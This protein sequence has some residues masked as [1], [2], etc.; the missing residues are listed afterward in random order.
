MKHLLTLDLELLDEIVISRNSATTGQHRCLPYIPGSGLLGAAASRL[1]DETDNRMYDIFHS[2]QVRFGDGR[3]VA[4]GQLASWPVPFAWHG[5]K[6]GEATHDHD[7]WLAAGIFSFVAAGV[8]ASG[9]IQPQQIR[10]GFVSETG[11][12][13]RP[14]TRYRMKTAIDRRTG[15]A[16]ESQLF[17]YEALARGQRFRATIRSNDAAHLE[18]LRACLNDVI[19]LGR[20]RSA[21]YGRVRVSTSAVATAAPAFLP[22]ALLDGAPHLV[23]WLAS[24]LAVRNTETGMPTLTP[25]LHDLGLADLVGGSPAPGRTFVRTRRYIPYN[26]RRGSHDLERQVIVAG[27]VLCYRLHEPPAPEIAARLAARLA[28]GL[29]EN[30]EAGLGDVVLDP[31]LEQLLL[32]PHPVFTPLAAP[33]RVQSV[34]EPSH[35]LIA[36]L[37]AGEERDDAETSANRWAERKLAALV[38]VCDSARQYNGIAADLACGPTAAQWGRV[39]EAAIAHGER[40]A[41][42]NALVGTDAAPAGADSAICKP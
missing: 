34:P 13:I 35:P 30:R 22:V 11:E 38:R 4:H 24:D 23:L 18:S 37:R 29:G 42:L 40:T 5:D 14:K 17:G 20:S 36:W 41:L 6:G 28:D 31:I 27:S 26:A 2:G 10:E 15:G 3:P 39:Q 1:Y 19:H 16:A 7:R 21:Q 32:S 9:F 8:A 33:V 25:T 12:R